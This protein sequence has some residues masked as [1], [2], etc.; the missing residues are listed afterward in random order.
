MEKS[1]KKE[2]KEERIPKKHEKNVQKPKEEKNETGK[3]EK[4][5]SRTNSLEKPEKAENNK[6]SDLPAKKEIKIIH[7]NVNGLRPL[8]NKEELDQLVKN[9]N[10]D[11]VCFNEIKIDQDTIK[12]L[13]LDKKFNDKYK[14]NCYWNCSTEKKGY[15]GT[16]ILSKEKPESIT[17]GMNIK[18]HDSEGRVIT[19]EYKKFYLVSCYTPNAGEKLK[20]IDYRTKE[21]DS[22]FFEYINSLKS[23]KDVIVTGDLNV[24]RNDMDIFEPKGKDKLPGFTKQEKESFQKFLDMGYI[25]TFRDL[26]PEE[27]KY[28]FFSKRTKGKESNKGWRLDYFVVNKD[29]KNIEVKESDMTE[30]DKYNASDHIPIFLTFN[31]KE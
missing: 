14:F 24:A 8:L 25:D 18:K 7:W 28:S 17:Y 15:A 22:D 11:I 10:P 16:A 20:R 21:W 6:N 5:R 1:E 29:A 3:K 9:E 26:H 12:S 31:L 27:K 4:I 2:K 19:A 30:K 13:D 23:K